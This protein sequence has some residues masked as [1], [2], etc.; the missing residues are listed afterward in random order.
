[1]EEFIYVNKKKANGL[2]FLLGLVLYYKIYWGVYS[3]VFFDL[4][5]MSLEV[6]SILDFIFLFVFILSIIPC[7]TFIKYVIIKF[8]AS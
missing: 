1:M 6:L 2:F 7:S 8:L 3:F 4:F 5:S